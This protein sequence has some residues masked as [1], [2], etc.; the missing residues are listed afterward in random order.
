MKKL[1]AL[2]LILV[3]DPLLS[4]EVDLSNAIPSGQLIQNPYFEAC[5][6]NQN[7]PTCGSAPWNN[8]GLG[9]WTM[10]GNSSVEYVF[11]YDMSRLWQNIDITDLNTKQFGY[12]LGFSLNASCKNSI[13]GF[14][15]NPDGPEDYFSVR[16]NYFS[17][18]SLY[19]QEILLDGPTYTPG[20]TPLNFS[21]IVDSPS[22]ITTIQLEFF[23]QDVGFWA[24]FYGPRLDNVTFSLLYNEIVDIA[25]DCELYPYDQ[26]CIIQDLTDF[27][28]EED[29]LLAD[30]NDG[31]DDGSD[32]G[33]EIFEEEEEETYVADETVEE[34][35][36]EEM[37]QDDTEETT[38]EEVLV[39]EKS[40]REIAYR[41]LTDE[42]KAQILADSISK[43]ALEFAL[44]VSESATA[45]TAATTTETT[46]TMT[47][48]LVNV[49]DDEADNKVAEKDDSD[50]QVADNNTDSAV[51]LLETGRSI[52][53]AAL[54]ATMSQTEQS[55]SDSINQAE[56]IAMGSVENNTNTII[57]TITIE[58]V[59][60]NNNNVAS[61]GN[62][63]FDS[64]V[65]ET[66]TVT[67]VEETV[68]N[69]IEQSVS[70][71]DSADSFADIVNI[72]I[73][74]VDTAQQDLEFVQSVLANISQSNV[75]NDNNTFDEDEQITIQ[76]D[77]N[78]SNAFNVIPNTTNLEILGVLGNKQEEKTD[79]EKRADQAVAANKEQQ[80]EINKNYMDADQSGIVAAMSGDTDVS[81][82]RSAMLNDNNIWYKP[83]DI[84]KNVVY[85]DN[86]RGMYF[87]EKGNTDTYKKM[88]DEQYK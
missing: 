13:G 9:D 74:I 76:N 78:L 14:C 45:A 46:T 62:S 35:E 80:E 42:E 19:Q 66:S 25:V 65:E 4:Q 60:D 27:T 81:S 44:S 21:G 8:T 56:S 57:E 36:L 38:D 84:Y 47:K 3:C 50:E 43:N 29:I 31:S 87:L 5:T 67:L 39:A 88:V 54:S 79:A 16:L 58:N 34:T 33:S 71:I 48:S 28:D 86:V 68:A 22:Q 49:G 2:L 82:Y 85:K 20:W 41:E 51:D 61:T 64:D 70:E 12:L 55:A 73:A 7:L 17:G 77:P 52:G 69:A 83:E 23:G 63:D 1:L 37:L 15:E 72:D 10:I 53:I 11:S 18:E 40:E 32:D 59:I 6:I 24:G 30:G 26:T 75:D